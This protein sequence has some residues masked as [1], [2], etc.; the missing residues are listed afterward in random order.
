MEMFVSK[1]NNAAFQPHHDSHLV[2]Q[3]RYRAMIQYPLPITTFIAQQLHSI[4]KLVILLPKLGMNRQIPREA[5]YCPR[6]LG[7]QEKVDFIK[8]GTTMPLT[9]NNTSTYTKRRKGRTSPIHYTTG[10]TS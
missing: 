9:K 1:I 4:Q 6:A 2:Y 3:S 5:I 8:T 7:G 10:H